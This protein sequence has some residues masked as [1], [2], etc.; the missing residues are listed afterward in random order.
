MVE[1]C[2]LDYNGSLNACE[3]HECVVK[4]ENEWRA[5]YCPE[6]EDLYCAE[7]YLCYECPGAWNCED[8]YNITTEIMAFYDTN[9]DGS[10]NLGDDIEPAHLEEINMYCDYSGD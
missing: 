5:E 3:I 6:S 2:D 10:I 8:I 1:Y 4:C 9:G 7:P